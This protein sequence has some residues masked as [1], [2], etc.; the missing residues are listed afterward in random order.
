M[1]TQ[2]TVH[3]EDRKSG[4]DVRKVIEAE[5]AIEAERTAQNLGILVTGVEGTLSHWAKAGVYALCAFFFYLVIQYE[6]APLL[7]QLHKS[8]EVR[9]IVRDLTEAAR[10]RHRL[11]ELDIGAE[12]EP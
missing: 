4:K 1:A 5:S 9:E 12:P 10:R 8:V 6:D 7:P 3:G 11:R 2:Y